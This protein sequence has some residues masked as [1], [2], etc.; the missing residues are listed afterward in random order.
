MPKDVLFSVNRANG[1]SSKVSPLLG[2]SPAGS[3]HSNHLPSNGKTS[4][5]LSNTKSRNK[6]EEPRPEEQRLRIQ[7]TAQQK[8]PDVVNPSRKRK[9]L[10]SPVQQKTPQSIHGVSDP[11]APDFSNF[12]KQNNA[13]HRTRVIRLLVIFAVP[14][15]VVFVE[16]RW[17]PSLHTSS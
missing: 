17:T 10:T 16:V 14:M 15:I 8:V 2:S 6:I 13:S 7:K 3:F 12:S 9:P 4:S 1:S 11:M 5:I